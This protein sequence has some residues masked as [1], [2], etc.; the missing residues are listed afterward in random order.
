MLPVKADL[1]ICS[2]VIGVS[3]FSSSIISYAGFWQIQLQLLITWPSLTIYFEK[4]DKS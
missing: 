3:H 1:A 2:P 4:I